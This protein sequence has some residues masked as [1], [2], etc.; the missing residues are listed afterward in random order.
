MEGNL[1]RAAAKGKSGTGRTVRYSLKS[2]E[3]KIPG[4]RAGYFI[5]YKKRDGYGGKASAAR[6][7]LTRIAAID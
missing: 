1:A 3:W 6:R 7:P 4:N 5:Y 2:N